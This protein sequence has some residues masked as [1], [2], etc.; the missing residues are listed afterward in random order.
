MGRLL[1]VLGVATVSVVLSTA[2]SWAGVVVPP[3]PVPEPAPLAIL[4][5]GA[6]A[7]LGLRYRKRNRG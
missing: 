1:A 7:I 3:H 5:V 2:E 6:V 4:A